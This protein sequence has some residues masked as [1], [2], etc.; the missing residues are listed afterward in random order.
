MYYQKS[1]TSKCACKDFDLFFGQGIGEFDIELNHQIAGDAV[2]NHPQPWNYFLKSGG[3]DRM[4]A[5]VCERNSLTV[6]VLQ[7][8]RKPA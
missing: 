7:L 4:T 6:Q 5:R 1:I 2:A 3:D 8:E